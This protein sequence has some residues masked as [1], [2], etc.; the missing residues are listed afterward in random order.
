MHRIIKN[1]QGRVTH[2]MA[3]VAAFLGI[4]GAQAEPVVLD[5]PREV[6]LTDQLCWAAV[7]V[8]ALRA[9]RNSGVR[10][11]TQRELLVYR[12]AEVRFPRDIDSKKEKELF[13]KT[14]RDCDSDL[15]MCSK[16]GEPWLYSLFEDRVPEGKA[17]SPGHFR[18]EIRERGRPVII[19][20]DYTDVAQDEIHPGGDHFLI[21]IGI[22]DSDPQNPL[23]KVWNPWPTKDAEERLVAAG[24]GP[25]VRE[26][27][28][29]YSAYV[30][31][32]EFP[33]LRAIHGGDRY[34]LRNRKFPLALG[35][36]KLIKLADDHPAQPAR[37]AD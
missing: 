32:D 22:D 13:E 15:Q 26:K 37:R 19:E 29:P 24:R 7:S 16:L 14:K 27:W 34:K 35:Y 6:Q 9:F 36:P 2:V 25:V 11:L 10:Q 8:M 20:W 33:G 1:Q 30:T 28:I 12:E 5:I 4:Q 18:K 3:S 31:P 17:L 21:V 23:L